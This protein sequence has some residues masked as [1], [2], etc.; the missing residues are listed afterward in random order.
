MKPLATVAAC[1]LP[2]C[3]LAATPEQI[4]TKRYKEF[5]RC[6]LKSDTKGITGWVNTNCTK[7]FG[8][9]SYQKSKFN[10][11]T[12]LSGLFQQIDKTSKVLKSE[13]IIRGFEKHGS[14]ITATI[15]MDFK[16]IVNF[17]NRHLT[18]T[19]QSV[20]R[21]TWNYIGKDWK[22]VKVVQVN[23]DTQMQQEEGANR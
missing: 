17:D 9:T 14:S 7:T 2:L 23:A 4:L 13:L 11:E 16:G 5:N 15:S 1:L 20:T 3:A 6:I 10:R 18:L 8:Y 19:D 12:F 21:E 22:L